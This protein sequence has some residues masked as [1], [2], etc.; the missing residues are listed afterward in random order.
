MR[1][2]STILAAF[3]VIYVDAAASAA[4]ADPLGEL[5]KTFTVGGK[6]V[7]PEIFADFGDANLADSDPIVVTIDPRAATSGNRY[8]DPIRENG[9]WIVQTKPNDKVLNGAEETAYEYIGLTR[10][11]LLVVVASFNGG[12][13]GTF[14]TLH[15]LDA[16]VAPAVDAVGKVYQRLNLTLLRSVRLGDRWREP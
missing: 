13:S 12:G 15:V 10:D 3:T 4:P 16:T 7:P 8:A 11:N 6:R 2:L 9:R 14:Y 5:R 1:F